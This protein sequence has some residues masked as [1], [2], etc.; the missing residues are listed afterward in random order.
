MG[1][2]GKGNPGVAAVVSQ[3]PGSLGYVEEAFAQQNKISYAA[4]KNKSGKFVKATPE[5]VS[6]AGAGA[7]GD[8]KGNLLTA[9]IWDQTGEDAYPI[10]TF[11]YLI[12]YK[13]LNN[14]DS[15]EQAQGLVDF[16]WWAMH[17]GQQYAKELDYAPL[18]KPVQ[19]KVE[20]A[21]KELTYKGE[22]LKVGG[23]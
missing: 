18:A 11:T 3:T 20:A 2:G 8:M 5:S 6:A 23:M 16:L 17:D 19:E 10:S 22:K 9:D 13:D 1:Q 15:K 21:M 7:V 4:V 14:L 12:V